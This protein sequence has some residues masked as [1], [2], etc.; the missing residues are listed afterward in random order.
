MSAPRP[1][2]E[3][4]F[5]DLTK[6][7]PT[8]PCCNR[9][10]VEADVGGLPAWLNGGGVG[11]DVGTTTTRCTPRLEQSD[12]GTAATPQTPSI[13]EL[14]TAA[15]LQLPPIAEVGTTTACRSALRAG[16]ELPSSL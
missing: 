14:E 10:A 5:L 11:A 4:S 15:T 8:T 6:P 16:H 9:C 12:V 13:A 7:R 1:H 3:P 2:D